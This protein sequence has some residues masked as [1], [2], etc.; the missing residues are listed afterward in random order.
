MR[1]VVFVAEQELKRV[2]PQW[3]VHGCFRLPRPEVQMVEVIRDGLVERRQLG[4]DQEVVMAG[5]GPLDARRCH[6]HADETK[7]D[8]CLL[9]EH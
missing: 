9:G 7:A 6:P 2:Y 8:R 4:I 5:I 3:Q 1:D